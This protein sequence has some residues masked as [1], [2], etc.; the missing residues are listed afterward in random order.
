MMA[1]GRRSNTSRTASLILSRVDGLGAERLD[2]HRHR[3]GD[4]DGVRHLH[5]APPGG[6][7][8]HDV[9]GDPPGG[10][11]GRPIDLGRVLARERPATVAGRAAV[12]VDDDLA[13]GEP[14]VGVGA[15]ELEH[16]G[17][18]HQHPHVDRVESLG[19]SGWI[20][21][22]IR[23]GLISVSAS[24]PGWCCVEMSTVVSRDGRAVL[25]A[26]VT[27]VLPS[28]RRYGS[29][30]RLADLGEPLGRRCASQIG[31]GMRSGVSS[32]GIPEHH[33]LVAGALGVRTSSPDTPVR[34]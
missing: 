5:L 25:V 13:T 29:H 10:V 9:L 27:C 18:V 6:A 30:A 28:G 19:S 7:G 26:T 33:P 34:V 23:S 22:S 1:A 12:G 14:G 17:G 21:C 31:S 15:A 4:A 2:Q 32:T 3:L 8:R 24:I 20:T 11:R 16:A